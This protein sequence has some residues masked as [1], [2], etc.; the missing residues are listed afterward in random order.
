MM[1]Q[2]DTD[3]QTRE[4][5]TITKTMKITNN[6]TQQH[7]LLTFTFPSKTACPLE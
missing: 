7:Y 4:A 1:H 3:W 6:G 2:K 5:K